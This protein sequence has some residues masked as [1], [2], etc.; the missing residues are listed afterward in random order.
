MCFANYGSKS[1]DWMEWDGMV[2]GA[3]RMVI[4]VYQARYEAVKLNK[5]ESAKLG[6]SE[7]L[8]LLTV[9]CICVFDCLFVF[10][11]VCCFLW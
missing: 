11:C 3:T 9:V 4:L 5:G 6:N 10:V 1:R 8:R 2:D 7:A